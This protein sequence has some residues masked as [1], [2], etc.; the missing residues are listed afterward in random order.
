MGYE[1][2]GCER[3]ETARKAQEAYTFLQ[4]GEELSL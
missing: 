4:Q 3:K 1:L 2:M